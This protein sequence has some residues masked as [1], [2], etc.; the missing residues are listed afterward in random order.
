MSAQIVTALYKPH[1]GKDAAL[2]ALIAEHVPTLRRLNLITDRPA[3][4]AQ[5]ADGT[6]IE[7]FEWADGVEPHGH[8]EVERIW[9]A[10]AD[11]ADFATWA[12]LAEAG[13]TFPHFM[14]V[15]LNP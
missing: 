15:S 11:V 1:A 4:L 7:V 8:A 13:R 12:S 3:V 9:T 6:Y 10:M 2:R 5:A 14:P